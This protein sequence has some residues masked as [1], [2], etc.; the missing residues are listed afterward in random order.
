MQK[1]SKEQ[2]GTERNSG[3]LFVPN[4][5]PHSMEKIHMQNLVFMFKHWQRD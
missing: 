5:T 3:A 4:I 2:S 1:T